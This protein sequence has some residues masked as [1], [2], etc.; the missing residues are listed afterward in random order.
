[1][2]LPERVKCPDH[3]NSFAVPPEAKKSPDADT[4]PDMGP[5]SLPEKLPLTWPSPAMVTENVPLTP[6]EYPE[7]VHVPCQVP[8]A[9][10]L[11]GEP[12][13][14]SWVTVIVFPAMVIVPVR[15]LP[16]VLA[17]TE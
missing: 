13:D 10:P 16:P 11:K 4:L 9:E 6:F 14:A 17:G 7:L 5:E 1:M 3:W 15:W 2:E 8:L 12:V